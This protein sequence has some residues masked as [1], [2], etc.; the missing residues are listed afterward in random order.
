[1][2][3]DINT[4]IE[5]FDFEEEITRAVL[6]ARSARDSTHMV[7]D[8]LGSALQDKLDSVSKLEDR[9]KNVK[10]K[11]PDTLKIEI[12]DA[13]GLTSYWDR[14]DREVSDQ[15]R[16]TDEVQAAKSAILA[17]VLRVLGSA[18]EMAEWLRSE[19]NKE[20]LPKDDSLLFR[21][22]ASGI[23]ETVD[24][25]LVHGADLLR[26]DAEAWDEMDLTR[27]RTNDMDLLVGLHVF[28][29]S[30]PESLYIEV[31]PRPVRDGEGEVWTKT[32]TPFKLLQSHGVTRLGPQNVRASE[33]TWIHVPRNNVAFVFNIIRILV[34]GETDA[35]AEAVLVKIRGMS[36]PTLTYI[37]P[38]YQSRNLRDHTGADTSVAKWSAIIF[39][40]LVLTTIDQ[41]E[42]DRK[43]KEVLEAESSQVEYMRRIVEYDLLGRTLDEAYYP[44]LSR[45]ALDLRNQ[46]QVVSQSKDTFESYDERERQGKKIDGTSFI[47]MVPQLWLYKLGGAVVSS[48][49]MPHGTGYALD[50]YDNELTFE[51]RGGAS[52]L[53]NNQP[54]DA[55]AHLGLI[56]TGFVERFGEHYTSNG[57]KYPPPL[58][59]FETRVV[60]ILSEVTNYVKKVPGDASDINKLEYRRERY[61]IHVMSDVRSELAMIKH[62]LEQQERVLLQ[63]LKDCKHASE[64]PPLPYWVPIKASQETIQQYMRRVDK[65]DGDADRI[66]KNIQDM[67]NLKRTHASI[68]DAH[69]SLILSTAVIGFTV[70][71]IVFTPLAF[72]TALFALKIDGFENLQISGSDGIFHRGKISGIFVSTEILTLLLTG[73]AVWLA[74][75]YMNRDQERSS[76]EKTVAWLKSVKSRATAW[77]EGFIPNE[78]NVEIWLTTL[79]AWSSGPSRKKRVKAPDPETPNP[80]TAPHT[81]GTR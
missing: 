76:K 43:E 81:A 17:V 54:V 3:T 72:L 51:K 64:E 50:G 9:L 55:E 71:T 27:T 11:S 74:F 7:E 77:L 68:R 10:L 73:I 57:V 6:Y 14:L 53:Q 69:S 75:K 34:L 48:Y 79:I 63:F 26:F 19:I 1:M 49:T 80:A 78:V 59:L 30:L 4:L 32:T 15:S 70:I 29:R 33:M 56:M 23:P 35:I 20:G 52:F 36:R 42:K 47:L 66:E 46:D 25:L 24:L 16:F 41:Q 18:T 44:G 12:E 13:G 22:A 2:A 21:A 31:S 28:L 38:S 58:D 60:G 39:P 65:I 61:F 40:Y 45:E 37:E 8:I 5:S 62:T 67:L